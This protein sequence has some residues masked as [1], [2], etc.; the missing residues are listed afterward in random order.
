MSLAIKNTNNDL[1]SNENTKPWS[2]KATL[3]LTA[4]VFMIYLIITMN[5]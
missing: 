3:G 1:P 5:T 4:L 2:A